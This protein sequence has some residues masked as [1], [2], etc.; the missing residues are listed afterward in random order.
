MHDW[1][2]EPL[3]ETLKAALAEIEHG[4]DARFDPGHS[5][6]TG[7]HKGRNPPRGSFAHEH[8]MDPQD[9]VRGGLA[10]RKDGPVTRGGRPPERASCGIMRTILRDDG[11]RHPTS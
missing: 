7:T 2:Y 8:P 10:L 5:G 4:P 6:V 11:R 1:T 3:I 9:E